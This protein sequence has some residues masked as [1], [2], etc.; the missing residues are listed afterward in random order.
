MASIGGIL[1]L[2]NWFPGEAVLAQFTAKFMSFLSNKLEKC[3]KRK[4]NL[5]ELANMIY[6]PFGSKVGL[7]Q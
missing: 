7:L 2:P 6:D 4:K 5:T 1:Y 3:S